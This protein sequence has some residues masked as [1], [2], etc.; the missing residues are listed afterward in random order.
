M[1]GTLCKLTSSYSLL[2]HINLRKNTL[3]AHGNQWFSFA[4]FH[5]KSD[6]DQ[7]TLISCYQ[8]SNWSH[9]IKPDSDPHCEKIE[10]EIVRVKIV[11]LAMCMCACAPVWVSDSYSTL[12][13]KCCRRADLAYWRMMAATEITKNKWNQSE[14]AVCIHARIRSAHLV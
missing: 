6:R 12:C 5:F 1:R 13:G 10:W 8:S 11:D 14:I 2:W 7:L 4:L 9:R 3:R